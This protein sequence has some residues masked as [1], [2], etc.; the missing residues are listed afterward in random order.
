MDIVSVI[1]PSYNRFKYLLN[2]IKSIK[3]QTYK[4]IEIIVVNDCSTQNEYYEYNWDDIKI[5]NLTENSKKK[6]GFTCIGY[7]RNK[8]IKKSHGRYISFCDDD[9]IWF[10]KKIELQIQYMNKYNCNMS[11]TEGIVGH[12]I[13]NINNIYKKYLSEY[14]YNIIKQIYKNKESNILDKGLPKIWNLEFVKIHN[15]IVTSSVMIE[16][17]MLNRVTLF[18]NMKSPGEDYDY[19]L[20]LLQ[21]TNCV[22]VDDICFY[23]DMNHGDGQHWIE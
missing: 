10:P 16:K 19:W 12:G 20:R 14:Y 21:Y 15:C 18:K 9:D 4:N 7:V 13:Y 6:F 22:Y 23:Y 2:T 17:K 11:C 8:G 5:I 3:E 1:I